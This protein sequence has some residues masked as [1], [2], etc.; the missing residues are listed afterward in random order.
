M[1]SEKIKILVVEDDA[2]SYG[3]VERFLKNEGYEVLR[4]PDVPIIDNYDDAVA[5]C[6]R[7][8]PHIAILD[9]E[10]KGK[11]DGLEIGAFIRAKFLSPV[12]FLSSKNNDENLRRTADMGADGFVVKLGKPFRLTQLKADI[13]RLIQ[14]ALQVAGERKKAGWFSLRDLNGHGGFYQMRLE[15]KNI[16]TITTRDAPRNSIIIH[17]LDGKSYVNHQS[18]TE[19]MQE[20]PNYIIRYNNSEAIN[21]R[22]FNRKGKSI[23]INFIDDTR[24]EVSESFRTPELEAVLKQL[25][26]ETPF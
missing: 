22:L 10:I 11:R 14:R 12:I 9:I 18:L 25:H 6:M 3:R 26:E 17:T 8:P 1:E 13:I 21:G 7:E 4:Q 16:R 19:F 23:W 2:I 24:Y 5:V 20:L 15:W